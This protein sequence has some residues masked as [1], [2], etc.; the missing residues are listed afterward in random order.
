M[1]I[2]AGWAHTCVLTGAGGVKCWGNAAFVPVDIP[3]LD[4]GVAAVGAGGDHTCALSI[5]GAVSCW[6]ANDAGQLGNGATT[7]SLIP[8]DVSGLSNGISAIAAGASHTCALTSEGAVKCWGSFL[9]QLRNGATTPSNVPAEVS[10]LASG[11]TAVAA[12]QYHS[13][14]VTTGGGVK[15][16]GDNYAGQ[17]GSGETTDLG[18]E[19]IDV[20]DLASGISGIAAGSSHTCALTNGGG[21][22]CWGENELGQLGNGTNTGSNV[23]VNVLGLGSGII[24]IAAGE[25]QTCALTD[26]GGVKC[27]GS[28]YVGELGDGST[29]DSSVPVDVLGLGSGVRAIAVGGLHT[30]VVMGGSGVK[31]WGWNY[32]GQLGTGTRCLR[33]SSLPV[34]VDFAA[35][36]PSGAPI[37]RIEH[38]TGPTDVLLRFDAVEFPREVDLTGEWFRPGPEFTLY[39]DGTVILRNELDEALKAEGPIIRARPFRMARLDEDQVQALLRYAI[40]D[41][42][43]GEACDRYDPQLDNDFPLVFTVRA[44]GLDRRVEVLGPSPLGPLENHLRNFDR[45]GNIPTKVYVPAGYWGN[46]IELSDIPESDAVPWPWPDI[47]PEAFVVPA[48]VGFFPEGRRVMSSD[49]ASVLG[50]SDNGGVVQRVYLR[51][52]DGKTLYFFSLLPML[53]DE[54]G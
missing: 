46:L 35:L 4:S 22:M 44:G 17:L 52:P 39:G 11:I 23:P 37:A 16:W 43:L 21:V 40:G 10:G 7:S 53:P 54:T 32:F 25:S 28:N 27:W 24:A 36:S 9:G 6:G 50:L 20:S 48:E 41:G 19:P 26:G 30:C 3:G 49:E 18:V 45:D 8:V 5:T 47:E 38:A 12:G 13:C 51:G 31:C 2:G 33:S 34:D 15:C 14:A 29:T 42:G 1:P